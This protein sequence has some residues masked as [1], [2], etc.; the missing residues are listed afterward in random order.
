VRNQ[1]AIFIGTGVALLIGA[2]FVVYK[3]Y[4]QVWYRYIKANLWDD[5]TEDI[6]K[7]LHPKVRGK[8]SAFIKACEKVGINLRITNDGGMRTFNEQDALYAQGRTT[9]GDIVTN[10]RSGKSYHNYGLAIDVVE[11]KNGVAIWNN[12]R[13]NEIVAIAKKLGF[14]W[15]GDWSRPD[16]PHF[17]LTFELTTSE[18]ASLVGTETDK[19]VTV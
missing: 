11:I 13:Q 15:G 18:L 2:T 14:E 8:V 4:P 12:P 7:R 9:S 5:Q 10:A 16:K 3:G 17:Q 6:I 1:K 19:Y